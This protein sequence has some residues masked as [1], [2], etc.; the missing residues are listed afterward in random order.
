M[1]KYII[2]VAVVAVALFGGAHSTLA[3]DI[4]L[5]AD[6]EEV[7]VG[8]TVSAVVYIS[9]SDK[10][11]NSAEGVIA[12]PTDILSVESI[13]LGGSIFSIWVEQPS[14]SNSAGS[15][16]FDGGVPNP[17]F[18]GNSGAVIRITF[19]TK[20]A[21]TANVAFSSASVYAND[22]L[23][24]DITSNR[25]GVSITVVSPK[26]VEKVPVRPAPPAVQSS[27]APVISSTTHT[28]QTKWYINN[29]PE[30]SWTLPDGAL[31]VR[32]LVGKS[33][34]GT[35]TVSYVPP[36]SNKKV[37]ELP[38]GTFF[39]SLQV[40]TSAGWSAVSRYRVNID[41]TPPKPF[42]IIFPHGNKGFETQPFILFNTTDDESGVS[43]YSIVIGDNGKPETVVPPSDSYALLSQNPGKYV[44][45]VTAVD[46]AGNTR[47]ARADF[48]VEAID[49]PVITYYP[50]KIE[51]GDTVKIRGTTYPSSGVVFY[52]REG[53]KIISEENTKSDSIGG[54]ELVLTKSLDFGTY[55]FTSRVT[56]GQGA[57]SNETAPLSISVQPK[58]ISGLID[59]VL[60]YLSAIILILLVLGSVVGLGAYLWFKI[61]GTI[62]YM[63]R[64]AKEAEKVS[65]KAFRLLRKD[66]EAHIARLKKVELKRK[67]TPEEVLFL[68]EFEKH[69]TEAEG[70]ITKEIKDI[71]NF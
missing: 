40:R 4:F 13:S 20:K 43:H 27:K 64:E 65:G 52:I 28:D 45:S 63:Y 39:F 60:K 51:S 58:F 10:A 22:G 44:L 42:S 9:S 67:L 2:S 41:T 68:E 57:K 38:D 32:T 53:D 55:T 46:N 5:S 33:P 69:L 36:I 29:T 62:R 48:T 24:T 23:G 71:S 15:I 49:S 34:D 6:S 21:G 8:S 19:R 35:P 37:D 66:I 26:P 59:Y 11:I 70:I 17:G 30:F 54:F 12:F 14:F 16:L 31:E 50:D 25:R 3:A 47:V 18:A 61:A 7:S 56:N 1:K